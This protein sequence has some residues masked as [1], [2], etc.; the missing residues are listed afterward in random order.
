MK[1]CLASRQGVYFTLFLT[2]C[3]EESM[4]KPPLTPDKILLIAERFKVLAEPARLEI[5]N[6][7]RGGELTVTERG[8]ARR[9]CPGTCNCSTRTALSRV[10]RRA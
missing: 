5:M 6:R 10:G 2:E 9:I 3:V 1:E 8:L 7:L 4:R